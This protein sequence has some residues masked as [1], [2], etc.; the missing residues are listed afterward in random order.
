MA[1]RQPRLYSKIVRESDLDRIEVIHD[2][3]VDWV[4]D[5]CSGILEKV[6]QKEIEYYTA[7][8]ELQL[9]TKK[10][11]IGGYVDLH[12]AAFQAETWNPIE[13]CF[14]IKSSI[15]ALGP[16]FRQLKWYR[17]LYDREL[18]FVVV[19][20]DFK[21]R[22]RIK[23]NGYDFFGYKDGTFTL[24]SITPERMKKSDFWELYEEIQDN[25]IKEVTK[26]E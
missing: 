16:L 7:E 9:K 25:W 6:F 26:P 11:V 15:K 3:I 13:V 1:K 19:S 12:V 23:D 24:S 17:E 10:G 21:Y 4:E 5:H 8:R 20:P 22:N 2:S 18:Y 14:E